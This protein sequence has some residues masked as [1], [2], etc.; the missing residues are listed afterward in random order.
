MQKGDYM[1]VTIV[2]G[3]TCSGKSH[4]IKERFANAKVIDLYDFQGNGFVTVESIW[5][6]YVSCADALKRAIKEHKD[7]VLEHTLLKRIRREWYIEQIRMVTNDEI[8]I[9]C[10]VPTVEELL[11]HAKLRKIHMSKDEAKSMLEI[12]EIP[13]EDEGY[14]NVEI[15]DRQKGEVNQT[16][17][18]VLVI[19]I[20]DIDAKFTAVVC[21]DSEI[22]RIT[23]SFR[24]MIIVKFS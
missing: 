3:P 1:A 21:A 24:T 14:S 11:D 15:I 8:K 13:T 23:V 19:V 17:P 6:S 2:M 18:F 9:I 10:I 16:S 12:L 5:Q 7:V 20:N 4:L 22:Q